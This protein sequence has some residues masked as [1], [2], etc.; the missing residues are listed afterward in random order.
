MITIP[1]H[2]LQRSD[3]Y[4]P[5]KLVLAVLHAHPDSTFRQIAGVLFISPITVKGIVG[6]LHEK[7]HVTMTGQGKTYKYRINEQR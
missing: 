4:A 5:G 3:I 7:G 6:S 1:T 2:I